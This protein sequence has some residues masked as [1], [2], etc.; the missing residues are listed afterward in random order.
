[1]GR[2][3]SGKGAFRWSRDKLMPPAEPDQRRTGSPV[4]ETAAPW[5][6]ADVSTEPTSDTLSGLSERS[7]S[8]GLSPTERRHDHLIGVDLGDIHIERLIAE[9][10]MGRVYLGR[11]QRPARPVAVKFMRHGRSATALERFR[12]EAE[13]LGRLSHPGIARVFSAGSLQI[14]LDD[15]PYSVME[16][17]PDAEPL[18]D[19][20]ESR[21]A[22][23]ESRLRLFLQVCDAV[24]YGHAQGVVHRDLKPG[25][26]LA[27]SEGGGSDGRAV[28]IDYGIAKLLAADADDSVTSTGEFLGTRR[29]MSPEQLAGKGAGIDA[30]TDVYALGL[31]LHELLTGTLPYDISGRSIAETAR[32]VSEVRPRPLVVTDT[33]VTPLLRQ[34]L[35]RIADRCLQKSTADRYASAAELAV[36]VRGLLEG[37]AVPTKQSPVMRWAVAGVALML[38]ALAAAAATTAVRPTNAT[39]RA[40]TLTGVFDSMQKE[41]SMP[42]DWTRVA[43][44][45]PVDELDLSAYSL[46]RDGVPVDLSGCELT[47]AEARTW[48]LSNLT[49]CNEQEGHY[50]LTIAP[51]E[52]APIDIQ[53]GTLKEPVTTEWTLPPYEVWKLSLNDDAWKSHVVSLDGLEAYTESDAGDYSFIRP[54]QPGVEG[55]LIM[56]FE[57]PFEIEAANLAAYTL[58]WTTGDPHPYDPGARSSVEVSADGE[59]WTVIDSREAGNGGM[60]RGQTDISEIVAGGREVWVRMQLT[61]TVEWPGDGLIHAQIMRCHKTRPGTPLVLQVAAAHADGQ[62]SAAEEVND[63]AGEQTAEDDHP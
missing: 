56:R 6:A 10:G 38:A 62:R 63:A 4:P 3:P 58:I 16:Y 8:F 18:V 61:A 7:L 34:G 20:C 32:I 36:D 5:R 45:E 55:T 22:S 23:V 28:V 2:G 43:F 41:R 40:A 27:T 46:T 11:Q 44:A 57:A 52:H 30:R 33:S 17:I 9:G 60:F 49:A 29:Y 47:S 50:V 53:G 37:I 59:T 54:T 24:A 25:N 35:K 15:V 51:G 42:V 26:I 13:V 14:G 31:I 1:M 12:K 48:R 21:K 39:P 19:F